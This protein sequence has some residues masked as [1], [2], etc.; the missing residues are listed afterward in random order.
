MQPTIVPGS[1]HT[2]TR[3]TLWYNNTFNAMG[4][5]RV[6]VIENRDTDFVRAWQGHAIEQRWFSA[7]NGS[8]RI[9]LIAVD[10]WENP[11]VSLAR[12][13]Y[14]LDSAKL[15]I[16]HIPAG[17]VS[18]IQSLTQGAKLLVMADFM[19]GEIKDEYRFDAGYFK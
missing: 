4:V 6:Y 14:I 18:S 5:K 19:L 3:G 7:L 1:C 9:Q 16:L 8:F 13:T 17:Y 11:P 2:D 12:L 10:N 15:D